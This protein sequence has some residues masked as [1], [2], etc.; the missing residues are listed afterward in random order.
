VVKSR[1]DAGHPLL[2][3]MLRLTDQLDDEVGRWSLGFALPL[4]REVSQTFMHLLFHIVRKAAAHAA[5]VDPDTYHALPLIALQTARK[6]LQDKLP[7][8]E[9]DALASGAESFERLFRSFDPLHQLVVIWS[10]GDKTRPGAPSE[11]HCERTVS[12]AKVPSY[13]ANGSQLVYQ[14]RMAYFLEDCLDACK[15]EKAKLPANSVWEEGA[16]LFHAV[17]V[18]PDAQCLANVS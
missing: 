14:E 10:E 13:I 16:E 17:R 8:M 12:Q 6:A 3:E 1:Y 11:S 18:I 5:Q 9:R 15:V 7:Q 2:D 4:A